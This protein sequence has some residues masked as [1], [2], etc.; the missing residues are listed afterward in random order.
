MA[1]IDPKVLA[2]GSNYIGL[3]RVAE[4]ARPGVR[5][6]I[7]Q[8]LSG[9][10]AS[11]VAY[12]QI[13]AVGWYPVRWYSELH[14]AIARAFGGGPELARRL[15]REAA[16]ADFKTLHRLVLSMLTAQT[17]FGQAHRI[18]SL[19]W[20][21]GEI[22]LLNV[23]HQRGA[24][25]FS[26]WDGFSRLVWEDLMGSVEAIVSLCAAHDVNCRALGPI[27]DTGSVDLDVRWT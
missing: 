2:K 6:L 18:M 3:L 10:L 5:P 14:A 25:R 26:G 24:L 23:S 17:V 12:G 19:Y 27:D 9:E 1:S 11:A 13:E 8:H 20:K 22:T 16:L 21:G 15:G 4:I 7:V